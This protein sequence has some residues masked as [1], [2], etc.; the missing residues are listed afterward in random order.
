MTT[1]LNTQHHTH[2]SVLCARS[3]MAKWLSATVD[4]VLRLP[5]EKQKNQSILA[6]PVARTGLP[7]QIGR[8]ILPACAC[9]IQMVPAAR[10]LTLLLMMM[11]ALRS[12]VV[13]GEKRD[14]A[15][16]WSN[17]YTSLWKVFAINRADMRYCTDHRFW[18]FQIDKTW[19][20]GRSCA[21]YV[22]VH[23]G[24]MCVYV[25]QER[26]IVKLTPNL[27]CAVKYEIEWFQL[28]FNNIK[29]IV[30]NNIHKMGNTNTLMETHGCSFNLH[31]ICG[32]H[33]LH[34]Q[35]NILIYLNDSLIGKLIR[36]I[37]K[38]P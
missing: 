37:S 23:Y 38:P 12:A 4:V 30:D 27:I 36:I 24:A 20:V 17:G 29:P 10:L 22:F 8:D 26:E 18:F 9:E 5:G 32:T 35:R 21:A 13:V 3:S 16:Q 25:W 7:E 14:D 34:T 28:F 33:V 6:W 19:R 2:R 1:H 31:L 15:E 11:F